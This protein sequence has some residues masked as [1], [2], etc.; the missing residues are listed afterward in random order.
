MGGFA[1]ARLNGIVTVSADPDPDTITSEIW[2]K[3]HD[4]RDGPCVGIASVMRPV[5]TCTVPH[6]YM[7]M[8][9]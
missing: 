7:R 8:N 2:V 9:G 5:H 4:P 1:S 3:R 6:T